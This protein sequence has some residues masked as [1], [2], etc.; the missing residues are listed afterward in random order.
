MPANI[1]DMLDAFSSGDMDAVQSAFNDVMDEKQLI[2]IDVVRDHVA[3]NMFKTVTGDQQTEETVNEDAGTINAL[4]ALG[5]V[6]AGSG[7]AAVALPHIHGAIKR[8]RERREQ[9]KH[10]NEW[11]QRLQQQQQRKLERAAKKASLKTEETVNEDTPPI[12]H[13]SLYAKTYMKHA[14]TIYDVDAAK[15]K[16]YSEVAKKHG[17]SAAIALFNYHKNNS[18]MSESVQLDEGKMADL[19]AD[20][21]Q[22]LDPHIDEYK[23]NGGAEHLMGKAGHVT[24]KIAGLHNLSHEHAKYFVHQYLDSKL[25]EDTLPAK[26]APNKQIMNKPV[27][28]EKMGAENTSP[29]EGGIKRTKKIAVAGK[30]GYEASAARHLARMGLQA[31]LNK[32]K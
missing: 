24:K 13:R 19:H 9:L 18:N 31:Q 23:K 32:A 30:Y 5:G 25:T 6:L 10:K 28:P 7:L 22:H 8:A 15:K 4:S 20:I 1:K 16:A 12:E 17:D 21:S 27:E 3:Q 26:L 29:F 2:A 14:K 11:Q